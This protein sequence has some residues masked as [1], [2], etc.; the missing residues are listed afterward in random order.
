MDAATEVSS[1]PTMT[2]S[3]VTKLSALMG[4][5][6]NCG[7][8]G[9]DRKRRAARTAGKSTLILRLAQLP[10]SAMCACS[11]LGSFLSLVSQGR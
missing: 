7:L 8:E 9:R 11:F 2:A 4:G 5:T 3:T 6:T 1:E 10:L